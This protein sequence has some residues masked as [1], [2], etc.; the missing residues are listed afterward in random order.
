MRLCWRP[1]LAIL[2]PLVSG[3]IHRT[4]STNSSFS[5]ETVGVGEPGDVMKTHDA[6][7]GCPTD[8]GRSNNRAML[9]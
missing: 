8:E 1:E 7:F 3:L 9:Q 5:H 4:S 6:L 2:Y